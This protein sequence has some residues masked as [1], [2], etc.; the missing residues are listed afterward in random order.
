MQHFPVE[1]LLVT[2]MGRCGS[3][4]SVCILLNVNTISILSSCEVFLFNVSSFH[5][6]LN[7]NT[8]LEIKVTV[9][10]RLV[11]HMWYIVMLFNCVCAIKHDTTPILSF[12][13]VF[14][15]KVSSLHLPLNRNTHL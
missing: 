2:G 12:Y 6:P 5:L 8:S 9:L 4:S 11:G 1:L 14:L 7:R 10:L 3:C 13:E 15:S